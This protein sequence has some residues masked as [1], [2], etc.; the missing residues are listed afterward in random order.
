[1]GISSAEI[2]SE[3][4]ETALAGRSNS[5]APFF[6]SLLI[7]LVILSLLLEVMYQPD[8]RPIREVNYWGVNLASGC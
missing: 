2:P 3:V 4:P 5:K 7:H 1:M 6:Y 8:K